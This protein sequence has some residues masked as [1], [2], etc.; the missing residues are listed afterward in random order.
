MVPALHHVKLWVG[1]AIRQGLDGPG[2]NT[3]EGEIFPHLSTPALGPTQ[4][5]TQGVSGLFPVGKAT[6]GTAFDHPPLSSVEF[7]ERVELIYFP[8]GPSRLV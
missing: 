5:P 6:R 8:F 2:S 1:I 4:P 3:G 7:K